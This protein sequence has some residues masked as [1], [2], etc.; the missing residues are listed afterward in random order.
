MAPFR[1]DRE[2]LLARIA[3]LEAENRRLVDQIAA[4]EDRLRPKPPPPPPPAPSGGRAITL[5]AVGPGGEV[6]RTFDQAVIKIGRM[7]SMHLPIDDQG[8]SRIHAVIEVSPE[9]VR[10]I[11]LGGI[12]GTRVNGEPVNHRALADG[13]RIEIGATTI[14]IGIGAATTPAAAPAAPDR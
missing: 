8:V 12:G 4:L 14:V 5:R 7:A 10:L 11:D 13:D 9:L 1:D 2:A 6:E 3:A